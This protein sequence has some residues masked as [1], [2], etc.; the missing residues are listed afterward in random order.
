MNSIDKYL[1]K[2]KEISQYFSILLERFPEY[3]RWL[4]DEK[5][6][7]RK[8]TLTELYKDLMAELE[9]LP[10]EGKWHYIAVKFRVFKQKHF[11]RLA[12]RDLMGLDS[13]LE[14]TAQLSELASVF[15]QSAFRIWWNN[16]SLWLSPKEVELWNRTFEDIRMAILG[17]GKLGGWELNFVSDIDLL[18]IYDSSKEKAQLAQELL[19]KLCQSIS[20]VMSDLVDGDRVFF[21]DMRLRPGG[22]DGE[23]VSPI[24]YAVYHYLV[25]GRSWERL[26]LTKINAIA[27]DISLGNQFIAEIQPFLFRRFLDFQAIDEIM[28]LRDRMLREIPSTNPGPGF[29]VKL[30]RGGIREIEFLVDSFKLIYGGRYR[31]LRERNT[32][33]C[34]EELKKE[35]FIS[36]DIA[37]KLQEA[38]IFLRRIEH[39]VQLY[40]NRQTQR[41]PAGSK[42][43]ERLALGLGLSSAE[44][45]EKL[46]TVTDFV[47]QNFLE[48]FSSKEKASS[49]SYQEPVPEWMEQLLGKDF[50]QKLWYLSEKELTEIKDPMT[51]QESL[52][53]VRRFCQALSKRPGLIKFF[54]TELSKHSKV[55]EKTIFS[56]TRIPISAELIVN[57]PSLAEGFLK[58]SNEWKIKALEIL[59]ASDS[60]EE[61]LHWLR[62]IKNERYLEIAFWHVT[63]NP[64][65]EKLEEQLTLL[66]DFFVD[67][68]Y[69]L[70]CSH[71]NVSTNEFPLVVASMGKF[72]SREMGYHS[73][74][75][76][77]FVYGSDGKEDQRTIPEAVTKLI[78]R[79]IR[80]I[81][82]PLQEGQGYKVDMRLRPTGNY[83]PL[84]VTLSSWCEYYE[85]VADL[86]EIASLLRF[87]PV[88]G[89]PELGKI[90]GEKARWY[91]FRGFEPSKVWDRLCELKERMEKE[92]TRETEESLNLKLG[93]GGIVEGEFIC[94]GFVI[95][96]KDFFFDHPLVTSNA[97]PLVLE[98]VGISKNE[99]DLFLRS[100]SLLKSFVRKVDLLGKGIEEVTVEDLKRLKVLGLWGRDSLSEKYQEW[101]DLKNARRSIRKLWERVCQ[102]ICC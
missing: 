13:F 55:L 87:R 2:V 45:F 77:V 62:R 73:D 91:S 34:I 5:Q 95:S 28:G 23:L 27:G 16:P 89:H 21:V 8:F 71:F 81:S 94:Q 39:W 6:V 56:I 101:T 52:N 75:D 68:S 29:D 98:A 70:V 63:E 69:K 64:E 10:D 47:H 80:L 61:K 102:K 7:L 41:I 36:K 43:Q 60:F 20:R 40:E 48:L 24:T 18:F 93:K 92:R 51:R 65:V 82:M 1:E 100:F 37:E 46:V 76:L 66:A 25:E 83:G 42:A 85:G 59:E 26:A 44:L 33:R 99:R 31:N 74:L 30:G 97:L 32:L 22:K 14:T 11:L 49:N 19:P 50:S 53:R 17:L 96:H 35:G 79:F 86:W 12:L 38:Y 9:P 67:Y 84:V 90:V 54:E 3:T 58:Q 4:R 88:T 15:L 78:Q 57:M 72:G